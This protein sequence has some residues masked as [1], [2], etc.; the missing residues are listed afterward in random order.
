[1]ILDSS[2]EP[3][4]KTAVNPPKGEIPPPTWVNVEGGC[5]LD[6]LECEY[7]CTEQVRVN[8]A[9]EGSTLRGWVYKGDGISHEVHD[10]GD[11]LVVGTPN[12]YTKIREI[13]SDE[14]E[15]YEEYENTFDD[16]IRQEMSDNYHPFLDKDTFM[17][18]LEEL[19]R[20]E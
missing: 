7:G 8:H 3:I 19:A 12:P 4:D 16:D 11:G 13:L 9:P 2:G 20:Y 18:L 6:D 10:F 1:M 5:S 17:K 15:W 14:V